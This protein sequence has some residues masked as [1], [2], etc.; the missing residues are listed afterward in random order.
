MQTLIAITL[1]ALLTPVAQASTDCVTR[2][3][4]STTITSCSSWSSNANNAHSTRCASYMSGNVRKHLARIDQLGGHCRGV[5]GIAMLRGGRFQ[6]GF[7]RRSQARRKTFAYLTP[8]EWGPAPSLPTRFPGEAA[9]LSPGVPIFNPFRPQR[10]RGA[11][12][13]SEYVGM[14]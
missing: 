12:A 5:P 7:G 1:L 11:A 6:Q 2:K 14:W 9:R 13:H 10:A 8:I 3:S 4:G